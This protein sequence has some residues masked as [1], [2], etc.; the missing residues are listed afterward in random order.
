MDPSTEPGANDVKGKIEFEGRELE[1]VST[2]RALLFSSEQGA[3]K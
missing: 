1:E 3:V 2:A